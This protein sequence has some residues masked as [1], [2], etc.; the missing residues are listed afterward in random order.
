LLAKNQQNAEQIVPI[1]RNVV[2]TV[3]NHK[4]NDWSQALQYWY[5]RWRKNA[6]KNQA[7]TLLIRKENE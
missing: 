5:G 2:E 6:V 3:M 1:Q 7:A 4:I